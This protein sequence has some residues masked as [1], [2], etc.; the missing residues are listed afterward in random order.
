MAEGQQFEFPMLDVKEIVPQLRNIGNIFIE[1]TD[2]KRPDVC[3]LKKIK[4]LAEKFFF[5]KNAV[6]ELS[7]YI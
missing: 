6:I 4:I 3:I 2:F 5:M 1:E 7:N